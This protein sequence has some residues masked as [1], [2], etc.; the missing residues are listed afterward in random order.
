MTK[1]ITPALRVLRDIARRTKGW[2]AG[3][4]ENNH[5]AKDLVAKGYLRLASPAWRYPN[6]P[7]FYE[8]TTL[9]QLVVDGKLSL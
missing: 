8:L 5:I 7:S 2:P 9:G 6:N 1:K 3:V 4:P